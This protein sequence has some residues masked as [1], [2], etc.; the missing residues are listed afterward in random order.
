MTQYVSA[1]MGWGN[2]A[3]SLPVE[4][5]EMTVSACSWNS[6]FLSMYSIIML[7]SRATSVN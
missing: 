7:V 3:L 2:T 5:A 4:H 1:R 6:P